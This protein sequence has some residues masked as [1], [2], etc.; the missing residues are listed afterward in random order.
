MT[1]LFARSLHPAAVRSLDSAMESFGRATGGSGTRLSIDR[2]QIDRGLGHL[3]AAR[4][5]VR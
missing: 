2:S 4:R 5:I 3:A 1:V